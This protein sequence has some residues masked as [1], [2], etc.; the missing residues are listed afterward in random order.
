MKEA[1]FD[2]LF[3]TTL[4]AG[5][6]LSFYL[7]EI[8][9]PFLL[10]LFMAAI[11]NP[12]IKKWQKRLKNRNLTVSVFL[13]AVLA[14][15][16]FVLFLFGAQI[17]HDFKRLNQAIVSYSETNADE[18]DRTAAKIKEYMDGIIDNQNIDLQLDSVLSNFEQNS[19]DSVM[20]KLDM[21]AIS[22]SLSSFTSFF[23]SG[24]ESPTPRKRINWLIVCFASIPYFLYILFTF[25]YFENRYTKYF[26]PDL[27]S[28]AHRVF[29]YFKSSFI[30]YFKQRGTIA[31]IYFAVFLLAF[32]ILKVPGAI[33]FAIIGGFLSFIPFLNLLL[34]LPLIPAL[35]ILSMEGNVSFLS[36]S[37]LILALFVV[38]I[39]LEQLV[40]IPKI[41]REEARLN[42]AILMLSGAAFSYM[43]GLFGVLITIPLTSLVLAYLKDVLIQRKLN[44]EQK[45]S[46]YPT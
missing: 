42:P 10:G 24:E 41:V 4:I 30:P 36:Y 27:N 46:N 29:Q 38:M 7:A 23:T 43:F 16:T 1:K 15:F 22:E 44:L 20:S 21:D 11:S 25:N 40:L 34:V 33:L 17:S 18:I 28:K 19:S 8:V 9:L 3:F 6:L 37:I 39:V 13:L 2:I 5:V 31:L 12:W 32:L 26:P 35:I 14:I 45:Q